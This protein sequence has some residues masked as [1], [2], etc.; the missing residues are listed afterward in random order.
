MGDEA[1]RG[2]DAEIW[3]GVYGWMGHG[4]CVCSSSWQRS[5][6]L[7]KTVMMPYLALTVIVEPVVIAYVFESDDVATTVMFWPGVRL[8]PAGVMAT[9]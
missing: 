2:T 8:P 9:D 4:Y 7:E 3:R 6:V 1:G 5:S